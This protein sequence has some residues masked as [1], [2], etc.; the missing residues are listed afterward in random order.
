MRN[1]EHLSA[2]EAP[3]PPRFFSR[4][5]WDERLP[6]M[7]AAARREEAFRFVLVARDEPLGPI[8]G[9]C[10]LTQIVRGPSQS[11]LLGFGI[12]AEFV[13]AKAS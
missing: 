5:Y 8:V 13:S 11:A 3:R 12:D 4:A 6:L 2:W 7:Q 9:T 10:S 1:R